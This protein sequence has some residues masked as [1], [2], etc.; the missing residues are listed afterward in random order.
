[1]NS[2]LSSTT[3]HHQRLLFVSK[4]SMKFIVPAIATTF[5]SLSSLS[6]MASSSATAAPS[7]SEEVGGGGQVQV[8]RADRIR[9]VYFGAL[10]A[11]ALCLGSHYEYDAEKIH[12]AY[13]GTMTT[14]MGP[15]EHMGGS[16]HGIGWGERNYHP[17]TKAGDQTDYGEY[18]VLVL[19]QLEKLATQTDDS[20]TETVTTPFTVE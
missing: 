16:T 3:N 12:K 19:E 6:T 4:S 9:G 15:G 8:K 5:L 2:I 14:Y 1:M 17:G 7:S 20:K 11:D 10:V 18:N 13:N